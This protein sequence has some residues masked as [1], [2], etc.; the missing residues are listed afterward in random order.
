MPNSFGGARPQFKAVFATQ[1]SMGH[2]N[3][4]DR[5]HRANHPALAHW[6]LCHGNGRTSGG[7][8]IEVSNVTVFSAE[9]LGDTSSLHRL[10][11]VPPFC[12]DFDRLIY[13]ATLVAGVGVTVPSVLALIW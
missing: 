10:D 12:L 2:E 3:W 4:F 6:P 5:L 7:R 9:R 1:N 11:R 13:R 8:V